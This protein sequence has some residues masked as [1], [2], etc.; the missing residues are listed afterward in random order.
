MA[1]PEADIAAR[2]GGRAVAPL[3][4]DV[5]GSLSRIDQK[6]LRA[7]RLERLRSELRKR[8]YMGAMLTDPLNIRYAT[9][10]RNMQVWTMHSPGRWAFVLT[11]GL[12]V[13]AGHAPGRMHGPYLHVSA[14][15]RVA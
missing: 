10:S 8:D 15:G 11:E 1:G 12:G 14:A 3:D 13:H 2:N 5:A 6:K 9:G 4:V 7:Y